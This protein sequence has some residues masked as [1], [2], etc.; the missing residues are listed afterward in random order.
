M[1]TNLYGKNALVCGAS[2]GI[3]KASAIQLAS[4]GAN[5]TLVSRSADLMSDVIKEMQLDFKNKQDHDFVVADFTDHS[6]LKKKVRTI[7][8]HRNYHILVNNTGG[9]PAGPIVEAKAEDFLDAFQQH[10]VCNHLLV[11]LLKEGMIKEG[12]GRII[13]IIS[14]SVKAPL[15]NL[16]VSNTTRGAVASWA[17]TMAN[18]LGPHGITVNNVLPGFTDT[19]RLRELFGKMAENQGLSYEE[20]ADELAKGV[21]LQRFAKAKEIGAAVAWLASPSASY[22]NGINL[23][24]D[25]GRTR[26][27]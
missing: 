1:N 8:L 3:G 16:G 7:L 13:N 5:V 26:S 20:K 10:L 11:G 23:P 17:K 12:Y 19:H 21:P 14:T 4:L 15:D 24:V 25:G 18:E 2:K 6:D 22:V 27:L 9:P